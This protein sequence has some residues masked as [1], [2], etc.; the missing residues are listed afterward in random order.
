MIKDIFQFQCATWISSLTTKSIQWQ[1]SWS[2][3]GKIIKTSE[4]TSGRGC[5]FL[6]FGAENFMKESYPLLIST[7]FLKY[8]LELKKN[9][10]Y[11][12]T[13]IFFQCSLKF[14]FSS[15]PITEKKFQWALKKNFSSFIT[16][17]LSQFE[18]NAK[19]DIS[20]N[21][22]RSIGGKRGTLI[23]DSRLYL[24][25]NFCIAT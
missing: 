9:F 15:R 21:Q 22:W 7:G 4:G 20:K 8:P 16:E 6:N 3:E 19:M 5:D 23:P 1:T 14:F 10:S 2:L 17:I 18:I 24:G 13:E 12:L 25:F 11:K